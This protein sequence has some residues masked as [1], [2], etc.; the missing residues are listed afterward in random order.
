M[1][2]PLRQTLVGG[3][4]GEVGGRDLGVWLWFAHQ[5]DREGGGYGNNEEEF[6]VVGVGDD[7]GLGVDHGFEDGGA[8]RGAWIEKMG[9]R[10]AGLQGAGEGGD[11]AGED[12]VLGLGG[13]VQHGGG[14]GDADGAADVADEVDAVSYTHLH[15]GAWLVCLAALTLTAEFDTAGL[16]FECDVINLSGGSVTI[17]A[18]ITVGNS[19]T[20]LAAGGVARLR[21][22]PGL[23]GGVVFWSGSSG[24]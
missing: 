11:V 24:G 15:N 14:E 8:A 5:E 9:H 4:F 12:G 23:S 22:L 2:A 20:V 18:G 19:A 17:G 7:L 16:G 21:G 10:A 3:E 1:R 6:V 13:V